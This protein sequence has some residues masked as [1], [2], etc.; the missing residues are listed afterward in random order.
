MVA[1]HSLRFRIVAPDCRV[2]YIDRNLEFLSFRLVTML[3]FYVFSQPHALVKSKARC[4][5]S[6]ANARFS[7]S[8]MMVRTHSFI[9]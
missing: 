5:V 3:R 6:S 8:P 7:G 9:E 1:Q 4:S 2:F